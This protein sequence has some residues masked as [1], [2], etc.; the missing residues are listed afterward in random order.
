MFGRLDFTR[1]AA[2]QRWRLRMNVTRVLAVAIALS[3]LCS[4][5]CVNTARPLTDDKTSTPDLKL[6]GA[7]ELTDPDKPDEPHAVTVTRKKDSAT[8]LH[9]VGKD[10]EKTEELDLFCTK[11]GDNMLLSAQTEKDGKHVF[12]IAKYQLSGETSLKV[13]VLNVEFIAAAVKK[14]EL[15]GTIKQQQFLVDVSLDDTPEN[16][17]KFIEKNG[18][19]C[20]SKEIELKVKKLKAAE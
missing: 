12:A 18:A 14:K 8:V 11:I 19:K 1:P 17:R 20:F 5:G 6:L 7:W 9:A 16:L 10:G 15:K 2:N 4:F 13:W 3:H